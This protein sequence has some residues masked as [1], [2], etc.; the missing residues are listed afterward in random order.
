MGNEQASILNRTPLE[1]PCEVQWNTDVD[2]Q[3]SGREGQ[4]SAALGKKVSLLFKF[5]AASTFLH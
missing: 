4:S 1:S 2:I 5:A 3:I